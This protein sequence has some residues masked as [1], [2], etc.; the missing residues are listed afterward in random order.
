MSHESHESHGPQTSHELKEI[1]IDGVP[2]LL[3]P[4]E[5][6]H[7][8]YMTE[9]IKKLKGHVRT[10]EANAFCTT[11]ACAAAMVQYEEW[12]QEYGYGVDDSRWG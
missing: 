2:Y 1:T 12:R 7:A 4:P 6:M 10:V 5:H 11:N 8:A 3:V 9:T